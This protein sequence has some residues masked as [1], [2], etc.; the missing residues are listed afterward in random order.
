MS[1]RVSN[2]KGKPSK[3]KSNDRRRRRNAMKYVAAEPLQVNELPGIHKPLA[4]PIKLGWWA[5][6]VQWINKKAPRLNRET[7]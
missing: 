6:T 3:N 1:K 2:A 5:R 4:K 7:R